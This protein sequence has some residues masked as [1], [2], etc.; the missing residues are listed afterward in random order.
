MQTNNPNQA[1]PKTMIV[2]AANNKKY[3][4]LLDEES[5]W[6][7]NQELMGA[8]IKVY[9][10]MKY[11]QPER[12]QT[13]KQAGTLKAYLKKYGG[14]YWEKYYLLATQNKETNLLIKMQQNNQMADEIF[15]ETLQAA[16]IY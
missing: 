3:A 1:E 13:M 2:T 6:I 14:Q 10:A 7:Y 11:I 9:Q 16:Q 8:E 12:L 4:I 5:K 15:Q